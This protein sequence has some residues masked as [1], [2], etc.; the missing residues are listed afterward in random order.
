[1]RE[2]K[3]K[4][5]RDVPEICAAVR[6]IRQVAGWSQERMARETGIASQT[7]SRFELGKQV[8]RQS[9]VLRSLIDAAGDA[10]LVDEEQLFTAALAERESW[11]GSERP[12]P[13]ITNETYTPHEW[14]LM[15]TARIAINYFPETVHLIEEAAAPA[16]E[17]VDQI[18]ASAGTEGQLDARFYRDLEQQ[19]SALAARKLFQNRKKDGGE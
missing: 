19:L 18:M 8:P 5:K 3:P 10:G 2:N 9:E 1:M 4:V 12:S 15:Q 6:R 11:P 13:R 16:L 7:I 17:L 14:R